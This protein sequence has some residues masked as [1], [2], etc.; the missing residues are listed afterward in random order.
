MAYFFQGSP[1][2]VETFGFDLRHLPPP[3]EHH[4]VKLVSGASYINGLLVDL[5]FAIGLCMACV[6]VPNTL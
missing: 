6:A 2:D 1:M 5:S 3:S 4:T